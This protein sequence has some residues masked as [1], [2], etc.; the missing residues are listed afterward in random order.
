MNMKLFYLALVGIAAVGVAAIW[1]ARRSINGAGATSVTSAA[2]ASVGEYEGF[3]LG[4]DS[5]PVEIVEFADFQCPAC[6]RFAI[7]T[8]SDVKARLVERGLARLRFH[9]FPLPNHGN[10]MPAHLA[11]ACAGEQDEFWAMHDQLF[12]NQGRWSRESRP[13]RRFREYARAIGL[14][15]RRCVGPWGPSLRQPESARRESGGCSRAVTHRMVTAALSLIGLL[16]AVY[17][18]LWKAGLLGAI[19][20]GT[21]G[22]ETVQL[23]EYADFLGLPVAFFGVGGYLAIFVASLVGLQP[24][25]ADRSGPTLL[26]LVLS[27][28]GVA[29][30]AYLTYLE[31]FVIRAWCRWCLGSAAIIGAIFVASLVGW[32]AS[33]HPTA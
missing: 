5:A 13:A 2:L 21:G 31:A 24:R 9:D 1:G 29:F 12:Y 26:L 11:A 4:S 23:S 19:V 14:P 7:L 27:G 25:W 8:A 32:R 18:S 28:L 15:R 3:V 22:C 6:A 10:A 20:C 16:V 33:R 17:L 30:T